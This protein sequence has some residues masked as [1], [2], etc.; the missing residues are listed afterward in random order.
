[1]TPTCHSRP[2]RIEPILQAGHARLR[3]AA[4]LDEQ[5]R[6]AGLEHPTHFG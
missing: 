2:E 6:T 1:M 4:V 3:R 5:Q